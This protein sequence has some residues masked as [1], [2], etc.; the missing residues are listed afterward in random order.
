M[1]LKAIKVFLLQ[2][3]QSICAFNSSYREIGKYLQV[4][5]VLRGESP[6]FSSGQ[7]EGIASIVNM[8]TRVVRK[9]SSSSLRYWIIEYLRRQPKE[10]KYSALILRFIKDRIAALLILEVSPN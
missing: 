4:K 2:L 1:D 8:Q 3:L 9:L 6:P 7:L 10:R 5:A